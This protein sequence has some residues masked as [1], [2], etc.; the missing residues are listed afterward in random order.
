MFTVVYYRMRIILIIWVAES[1]FYEQYTSTIKT[2][3]ILETANGLR[4]QPLVGYER[5]EHRAYGVHFIVL[6]MNDGNDVASMIFENYIPKSFVNSKNT[7][8]PHVWKGQMEKY[9]FLYNIQMFAVLITS[10]FTYY[11]LA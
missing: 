11:P 1:K 3:N 9:T 10:S 6:K 4:P 5:A 2:K 8:K 7:T